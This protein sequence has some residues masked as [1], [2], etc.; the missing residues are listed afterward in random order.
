[1]VNCD[2]WRATYSPSTRYCVCASSAAVSVLLSYAFGQVQPDYSYSLSRS[3]SR[4]KRPKAKPLLR[5]I[6]FA[7]D[8]DSRSFQKSCS[9]GIIIVGGK[10]SARRIFYENLP[11]LCRNREKSVS[12]T[13]SVQICFCA[14]IFRSTVRFTCV[15]GLYNP[16][17]RG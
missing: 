10:F 17:L 9:L 2:Q 5:N 13:Q 3:N 15:G 16:P 1:M 11:R 8:D 6:N 14:R 12:S 7:K 4:F